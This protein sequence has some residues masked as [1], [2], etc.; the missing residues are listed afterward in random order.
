[1]SGGGDGAVVVLGAG[2]AGL[3][4]ALHLDGRREVA[5]LEREDRVG[6]L[7]RSFHVDGFT[8]DLT[9]HL[10]HLRKPEVQELVGRLMPD[11]WRRIERRSF[12]HTHGATVPYPF[13]A[14]LH[15]LPPEIVRDCL[16]G[17]VRA[18]AAPAVDAEAL[19][20]GS[21][22]AW[23][24]AVFGD[25]IARHFLL[26]YNRKLWCLDPAEITAEW[27]SWSVPRPSLEEVIAGAVGFVNRGL[28]Y[29]PTF[30][31]P[32]AGG[33]EVLPEALHGALRHSL[34]RTRTE[35][36]SIDTERRE[37]RT[38]DGDVLRYADLVSTLP[39]PR[40]VERIADAPRA[41]R[42]AAAGLR[43]TSVLNVNLGVARPGLTD[44]HWVYYPEDRF[45]FY[46]VGSPT[47]FCAA[48]APPGCSSLYV[49]VA[50]ERLTADEI[51]GL[52]ARVEEDLVRCGLLRADDRIVAR[53]LA[54]IE[55][56]YVIYDAHRRR[57]LPGLLSWL[58]ARRVHSIG[59]YGR[60]EYGSMEDALHQGMQLAEA[61]GDPSRAGL[62][63]G[64]PT[65]L[66]PTASASRTS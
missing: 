64:V 45:V 50:R 49:E 10:L 39:L 57:H 3:S 44:R 60:W 13:Q 26:P 25:G 48:S 32:V 29:N 35:V 52:V 18:Q 4:T 30:Q 41:V 58:A 14:N 17:F 19:A 47:A 5:V 66:P 15:G 28:G 1:M 2:L 6:G 51:P 42:D 40:L 38:R 65:C 16:L 34:V 59:R 33:I 20:A 27:V 11:G 24:E 54:R 56:A 46:R 22:R 31:Y 61:L 8:F 12:I 9:G 62:S 36:A 63:A 37:V 21:F 43:A 7:T 23:A 55:P 53:H